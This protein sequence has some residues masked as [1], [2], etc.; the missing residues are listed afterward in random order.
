ME[1][2]IK[3]KDYF[4]L[5]TLLKHNINP[6]QDLNL[7]ENK[8]SILKSFG[9]VTKE[10]KDLLSKRIDNACKDLG[11]VQKEKIRIDVKELDET[12]YKEPGISKGEPAKEKTIEGLEL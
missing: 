8:E 11:I 12:Y 4:S 6:N 7:N 2:A 1:K 10:E 5:K 3:Y 9:E